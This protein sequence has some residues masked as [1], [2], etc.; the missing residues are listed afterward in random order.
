MRKETSK[1]GSLLL[2]KR[3]LWF[4]VS[5]IQNSLRSNN[6]Q[7]THLLCNAVKP[8]DVDTDLIP[9]CQSATIIHRPPLQELSRPSSFQTSSL[10]DCLSC[11]FLLHFVIHLG[12]F[13]WL[14]LIESSGLPSLSLSSGFRIEI[15]IVELWFYLICTFWIDWICIHLLSGNQQRLSWSWFSLSRIEGKR[16]KSTCTFSFWTTVPTLL[17]LS[18]KCQDPDL[19]HLYEGFP[20]VPF[21]L[22]QAQLL[23][24]RLLSPS[25]MGQ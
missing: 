10:S 2:L 21:P 24:I 12:S 18:A 22:F 3:V 8:K 20:E 11:Q 13:G 19:R 9:S 23:Q 14:L 5:P 15:G 17:C 6:S 7:S 25:W 16:Q 4:I 1:L